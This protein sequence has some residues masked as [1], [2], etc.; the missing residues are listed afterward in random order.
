MLMVVMMCTYFVLGLGGRNERRQRAR[1]RGHKAA[2]IMLE[3]TR[4]TKGLH[5]VLTTLDGPK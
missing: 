1:Q 4:T 2:T 5:Y 3:A